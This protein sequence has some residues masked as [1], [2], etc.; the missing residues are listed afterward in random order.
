MKTSERIL[1][2]ASVITMGATP[3]VLHDSDMTDD[4]TPAHNADAIRLTSIG[5]VVAAIPA[6]LGFFPSR[7]VILLALDDVTGRVGA[8]ARTDLGLT[9]A[10]RLRVDCADD[11]G[12]ALRLLQLQGADRLIVVVVDDRDL[13]KANGALIDAL[14]DHCR[15]RAAA[16][17]DVEIM[18]L[19]FVPT[20]AAQVRWICRHG[21]SGV[22]SDP[23]TC[24]A[25]LAAVMEGRT[26]ARSREE[27]TGRLAP[28]GR[29]VGVDR[30]RDAA[31]AEADDDPREL[32]E[33]LLAAVCTAGGSSPRPRS[34]AEIALLGGALLNPHVRDAAMGLSLTVVDAQARM[35]FA[36]LAR[37]LRGAPRAAAA[38]LVAASAYIR[39]DGPMTG[40][41]LDA[42]LGADPEYRGA[43][44]L[45]DA[46]QGGL[47]PSEVSSAAEIGMGVVRSLGVP[48][49]PRDGDFPL[50]G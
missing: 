37:R 8:S 19:V 34:D 26:I 47:T 46:F 33:E 39:G 1:W 10:G 35:L 14:L 38:T 36:Q 2:T 13:R 29:G 50:A 20:L 21:E 22:V 15:G 32:L 41:A 6:L 28:V 23:D 44:L 27:L 12:E 5:D 43:Q 49:P 4:C 18:D 45:A 42:A 30:C 25:A 7:S 16:E 9:R 31:T 40:I 17:P 24:P 11:I 48:L 3:R